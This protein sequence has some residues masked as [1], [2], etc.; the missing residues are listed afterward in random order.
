MRELSAPIKEIEINDL[1]S[2]GWIQI[3][4]IGEEN[5]YFKNQE[6]EQFFYKVQKTMNTNCN[7]YDTCRLPTKTCNN[8]CQFAKTPDGWIV[9]F[10]P[11]PIADH[12]FDYTFYHEN[13]DGENGLCGTAKSVNDATLQILTTDWE[14]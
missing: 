14:Y 2:M 12:S 10:D 1:P 9:Y 8:K 3:T 11:K 7:H 5:V 13:H 6:G 4:D